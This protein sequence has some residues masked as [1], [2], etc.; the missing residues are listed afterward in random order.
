[1]RIPILFLSL[2]VS[3]AVL[4]QQTAS[5]T[6]DASGID[7]I[8]EL[9]K[10]KMS[11]D[12][13]IKTIQKQ[14]HAYDLS[15]ADLL[16][17]QKAGVSEKIIGALLD[18]GNAP[19]TAPAAAAPAAPAAPPAP[20]ASV[21]AATP[22]PPASNRPQPQAAEKKNE[23]AGGLFSGLKGRLGQSAEKSVDGLGNTA[24]DAVDNLDKKVQGTA[25]KGNAAVNNATGAKPGNTA[26]PAA[27]SPQAKPAAPAQPAPAA[28]GVAAS[29]A[30]PKAVQDQLDQL[31]NTAAQTQQQAAADRQAQ[32]KKMAD[33]KQQ[34]TTAHPEGGTD[35]VKAYLACVQGPKPASAK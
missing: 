26:A 4:A 18:P 25:G 6:A 13:V 16:K 1:M 32:T 11:E 14:N 2:F 10:A 19:S 24:N 20:A 17:L 15:P 8:I 29:P 23:K 30:A 31:Q 35:L 22:Q 27:R 21:P 9:V 5:Q 33:C 12:L 3:T 34:A 28:N 7:A